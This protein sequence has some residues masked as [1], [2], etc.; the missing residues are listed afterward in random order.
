MEAARPL[1]VSDHR[2][3]IGER[4]SLPYLDGYMLA[5]AVGL[6]AF[7]AFTLALA[8]SDDIRGQPL[9][10][11]FRQSLYGQILVAHTLQGSVWKVRLIASAIDL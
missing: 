11:V 9:Y 4:F 1:T 6:I 8:T 2:A 5:A 10:F 3:S 7:S